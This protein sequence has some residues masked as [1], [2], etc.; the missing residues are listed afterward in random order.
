[1]PAATGAS[2]AIRVGFFLRLAYGDETVVFT[3]SSGALPTKSVPVDR[4]G[5]F[6][7]GLSKAL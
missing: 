2:R 7:H 1:M 6:G 4:S 5:V 3:D